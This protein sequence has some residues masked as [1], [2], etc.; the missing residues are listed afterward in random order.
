MLDFP[1]NRALAGQPSVSH[2]VGPVTA[3]AL[4]V[5]IVLGGLGVTLAA[6]RRLADTLGH[7]PEAHGAALIPL[8]ALA[9]VLTLVSVWTLGAGLL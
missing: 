5:V 1:F 4:Q 7:D 6:M 2:A 8:A 9:L 3:Y